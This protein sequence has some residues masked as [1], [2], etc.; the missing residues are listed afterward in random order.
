M[1]SDHTRLL[2][3]ERVSKQNTLLGSLDDTEFHLDFII[4]GTNG[5]GKDR[6]H[7]VGFRNQPA[8]GLHAQRVANIKIT[9]VNSG[10]KFGVSGSAI[11]GGHGNV[12]SVDL[13]ELDS[14][15]LHFDLR[16]VLQG[17][18]LGA[19]QV[20]RLDHSGLDTLDRH[21]V[22]GVGDALNGISD[23]AIGVT[24]T[25][26]TQSDFSSLM[27]SG[28]HISSGTSNS[29]SCENDSVGNQGAETVNV[30]TKITAKNGIERNWNEEI[31]T[32]GM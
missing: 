3:E 22:V 23:G 15:S 8:S 28:D 11:T 19:L 25:E 29:L 30:N 10:A 4:Q 26:E 24:R 18:D 21:N 32:K 12:D 31:V 5:K 14:G 6:G 17:N 7:L 27:G 2:L 1:R 9:T 13:V 20:E 16:V